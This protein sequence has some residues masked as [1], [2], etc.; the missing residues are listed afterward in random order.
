MIRLLTFL[1]IL[2]ACAS[3]VTA[4]S[5]LQLL[6]PPDPMG[7]TEVSVSIS[8]LQIYSI[9]EQ[10]QA[11]EISGRL[12][13]RWT[14]PRQA[15]DPQ[16]VGTDLLEY[17]GESATDMLK[18]EVWWPELEFIDAQGSRDRLAVN[19]T[20]RADGT[21]FYAERFRVE[22]KWP[23]DRALAEFPFDSH[24]IQ[25]TLEPFTYGS[26]A[27]R[28]LV[29]GP[30]N[31]P[32]LFE[33]T[34]WS[35][36][37]FEIWSTNFP[38]YH[39]FVP[40]GTRLNQE[41]LCSEASQCDAI[42]ACEYE[43]N[44]FPKITVEMQAHRASS[45]YVTNIIVPLVLIVLIAAAV[46]WM[47]LRTTHLGDRLALPF[48]SILTVVA[49]DLVTAGDLPNLWYATTLDRIITSSY[50]VVVASI[51]IVVLIDRLATTG[52]IERAETFNRAMRW[53]FPM[54]YLVC[55]IWIMGAATVLLVLRSLVSS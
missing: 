20:L 50:A 55:L 36:P 10:E 31:G 49:F 28:F 54:V 16:V 7:P 30:T 12:Y 45:H 44:G 43:D 22:V 37:E 33:P 18:E 52:R 23:F 46:F 25:L 13:M 26:N 39:C 24:L 5:P 41:E 14:D 47:D 3:P 27:V 51:A 2:L 4:E 48:T 42:S 11:F 38:G 15:F 34:E 53:V 6:T 19:L 17:Q 21:V 8:D 29:D 35:A 1:F 9:R 40:P 32:I